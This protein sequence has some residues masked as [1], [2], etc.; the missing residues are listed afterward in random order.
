MNVKK[1]ILFGQFSS[2]ELLMAAEERDAG[3][4]WHF[5]MILYC[6]RAES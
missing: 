3:M 5:R 4:R 6:E 1:Y 2:G